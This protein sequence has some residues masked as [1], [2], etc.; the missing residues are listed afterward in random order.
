MYLIDTYLY[1]FIRLIDHLNHMFGV[2]VD[3]PA[4]DT[5]RK[6][7]PHTLNVSLNK[8]YELCSV[9]RHLNHLQK[10]LTQ[11][12]LHNPCMQGLSY[13]RNQLLV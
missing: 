8:I 2:E 5:E 11:T 13:R 4:W 6:Y 1:S 9:K 3:P 7:K 10:V 12:V